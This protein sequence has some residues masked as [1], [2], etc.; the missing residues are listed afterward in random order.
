[1]RVAMAAKWRCVAI[2]A[3]VATQCRPTEANAT[4]SE[5]ALEIRLDTRDVSFSW[6]DGSSSSWAATEL[7]LSRADGPV[8]VRIIVADAAVTMRTLGGMLDW[9]Q[10]HGANDRIS[11]AVGD[12]SSDAAIRLTD[13]T[14]TRDPEVVCAKIEL[15]DDGRRVKIN[16]VE[17]WRKRKSPLYDPR[18]TEQQ[19]FVQRD[20][21]PA[22]TATLPFEPHEDLFIA[23]GELAD[24]AESLGARVLARA[25]SA[26]HPCPQ[27][28]LSLARSLPWSRAS[29]DLAV[30]YALG[31]DEL[32]LRSS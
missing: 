10:T 1:M 29:V 24:S 17:F 16:M 27:A 19:M 9:L 20:A 18:P 13:R 5:A 15:D 2:A 7:R 21:K 6:S 8:P 31:V 14:E 28:T 22:D 11:L 30:L 12:G 26:S 32:R 3:V 25:L 4:S 23:P